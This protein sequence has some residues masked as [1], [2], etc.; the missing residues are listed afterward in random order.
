MLLPIPMQSSS[1]PGKKTFSGFQFHLGSLTL[2]L[3]PIFF[4]K[5]K[6]KPRAKPP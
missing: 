4:P 6:R 3:S 1:M 2:I 5:G